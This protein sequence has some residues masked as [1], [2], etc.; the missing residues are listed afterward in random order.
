MPHAWRNMG[1][2]IQQLGNAALFSS[3]LMTLS[4]LAI[5]SSIDCSMRDYIST[6]C[7]M[8]RVENRNYSF[9]TDT[10]LGYA[11]TIS[12][13]Q[14]N[15]I[16]RLSLMF[17]DTN[18]S[19][20]QDPRSFRVGLGERAGWTYRFYEAEVPGRNGEAVKLPAIGPRS[21]A[22]MKWRWSVLAFG[23]SFSVIGYGMKLRRKSMQPIE[24]SES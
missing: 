9:M 18:I 19:V 20:G 4:M 1:W 12:E 15:G 17:T 11:W 16:E 14:T 13:W 21:G 10:N 7:A 6:Q 22:S 23:F 8:A 5:P 2:W 24:K 3:I